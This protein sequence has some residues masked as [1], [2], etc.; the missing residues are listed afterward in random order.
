M[1]HLKFTLK[2]PCADCP[3]RVDNTKV[4]LPEK[5]AKQIAEYGLKDKTFPCHKIRK[6]TQCAGSMILTDKVA[7]FGSNYLYRF[8][9]GLGLVNPDNLTGYEKVFNSV[10]E[11]V[12][13]HRENDIN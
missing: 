13:H 7:G 2:S 8:A 9:A 3:F 4:I 5:R 11:M 6:N 12:A 1:S 10:Q